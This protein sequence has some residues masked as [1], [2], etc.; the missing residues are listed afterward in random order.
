MYKAGDRV[1]YSYDPEVML[2]WRHLH[3]VHGTV[4][5]AGDDEQRFV[6]VKFDYK[7]QLGALPCLPSELTTIKENDYIGTF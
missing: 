5:R 4:V 2:S 7:P 1:E 6:Y 3:G